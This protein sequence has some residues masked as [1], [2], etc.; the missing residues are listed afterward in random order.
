MAPARPELVAAL[1]AGQARWPGVATSPAATLASLAACAPT[2]AD[3]VARGDELVLAHAAATGDAAAVVAFEREVM[4]RARA[5][6]DRYLRDPVRTDEVVQQLRIHLLVG[7]GERPRLGRYDGRAP[8]AA[9][10]A[11]C[12]ARLA[13]HAL[14]DLR[15]RRDV[16]LE[17]S[18]ALAQ[19]TTADPL[20]EALRTRH[21]S[22]LGTALR[23]ACADLPRRHRAVVHLLFVE[24]AST[25]E[26]A[27]VYQV[28]R[29]TVWRWLQE[30]QER[31]RDGV[32][33]RLRSLAARDELS[34]EALVAWV[35]DQIM[36]S[37]DQALAP[38]ATDVSRA[39]SAP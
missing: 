18:E 34:P 33:A 1:C 15:S 7:D 37:L 16:T 8:L 23:E 2:D 4:G 35:D 19:L 17:W 14:R 21:A 22:E 39:S 28:H 5:T 3:L 12:A 30:A 25:D 26:V 31:L 36:L 13:L 38:T 24:G 9:W 11:M 20:V 29:V 6:I 27:A 32:R 10:I